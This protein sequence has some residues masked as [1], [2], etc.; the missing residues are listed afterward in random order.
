[1]TLSD[2]IEADLEGLIDDWTEYARALCPKNRQ[3]GKA[4]LRDS[5]R[6]L[7]I[8]IAAD[9]R[10]AQTGAQQKAKSHGEQPDLD[11]GFNE[12]GRG[13]A[14]ERHRQGFGIDALVAE[15]RALRASVLR[16]WQ[17]T[18]R[19]DSTAFQEMIRFNEAVDQMVAA[20][21]RQYS[22]QAE[23]IRDLFTGVLAHD[24]R[25]PVGAILN[26]AHVVLRDENFS[27]TSVRA[28]VNLQHSA[29]RLKRL[30]DDLFIFTRTRL[31]DAMPVEPTRQDFGRIL[32]GSLDEVRAAR[33]DA[34]IVAQSAGDLTGVW[35]AARIN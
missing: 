30:I 26:S 21:V 29:E 18:N 28:G 15:F 3:H 13:H 12:I 33:P 17:R 34:Q 11:S 16:R 6:E 9:M 10:E 4:Q 5:A 7:L 27:S 25:S 2:F 20:S 24:M 32:L 1:M 14:T 22:L 31:G 23:H 35:D 8:G 19:L